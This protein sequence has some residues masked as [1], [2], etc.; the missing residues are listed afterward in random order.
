MI[1]ASLT[2]SY[3]I[4]VVFVK[5]PAILIIRVAVCVS[6]VDIHKKSARRIPLLPQQFINRLEVII[7]KRSLYYCDIC[8]RSVL[9]QDLSTLRFSPCFMITRSSYDICPSC[10]TKVKKYI[11]SIRKVRD[12][13][14]REAIILES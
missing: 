9:E 1:R 13:T 5:K 14:D 2:T 7:I 12:H 6:V 10:R 11:K 4:A 8:G 3:I